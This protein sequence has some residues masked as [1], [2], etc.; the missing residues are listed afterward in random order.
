MGRARFGLPDNRFLFVFSFD[1]LSS[2]PRKNPTACIASF[3]RAFPRGDEPVGLVVKVMRA[4]NDNPIWRAML[5]EAARDKRIR[6]ISET[7][8]RGGVLDLYRACDCFVSL[9]R[10]EG[11][12]RGIAEAMMLGKPVIVTGYSGSLDFA[13]PATAALVDYRRTALAAGDYPF[14]AGQNWAEPDVDHAAWWMRALAT[15]PD[16]RQRLARLGQISVTEA[17]SPAA[18]GAAYAAGL[19]PLLR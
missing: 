9:H 15:R 19:A 10:A 13:T 14:G 17:Y 11:F 6:V 4:P 5:A 2:F 1:V 18:V 16:L 3:K 7:L 8:S 12:G